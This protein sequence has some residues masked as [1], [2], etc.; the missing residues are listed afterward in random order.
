MT[1]AT[2]TPITL[3]DLPAEFEIKLPEP[4]D[5]IGSVVACLGYIILAVGVLTLMFGPETIYY[6]RLHGMSFLQMIQAY[7]GPII[8]VGFLIASLGQLVSNS[9]KKQHSEQFDA[10][11]AQRVSILDGDIPQGFQLALTPLEDNRYLLSLVEIPEAAP[12]QQES[13]N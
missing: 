9:A 1:D 8:T 3:D 10:L 12:E 13:L 4:D 5:F 7:P 11:L 6:N 2:N